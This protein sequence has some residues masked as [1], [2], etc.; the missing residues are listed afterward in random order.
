[1]GVGVGV[2]VGVD[3]E[4]GVGVGVGG[5]VVFAAPSSDSSKKLKE[6]PLIFLVG[7]INVSC[8]GGRCGYS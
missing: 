1:M 8:S 5:A 4:V 7:N 6:K 3:V 2:G